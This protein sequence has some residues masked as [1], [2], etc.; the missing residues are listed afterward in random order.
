M[1]IGSN[2]VLLTSRISNAL[3]TRSSVSGAA[4][5]AGTQRWMEYSFLS[6][7]AHG[8]E[9]EDKQVRELGLAVPIVVQWVKNPTWCL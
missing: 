6:P 2:S 7:G 3:P 9:E 1:N 8:S 4:L 5:E